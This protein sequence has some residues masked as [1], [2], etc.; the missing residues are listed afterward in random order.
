M[1][2]GITKSGFE[3]EVEKEIIEDIRFIDT[4]VELE[5]T[6]LRA[7]PKL[8]DL[9]FSPADKQRLYDHVTKIHGRPLTTACLAEAMEI[10]QL[11]GDEGKN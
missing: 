3:F 2:K 9:M 6:N 1:I 5:N 11:I 7:A 4:L 10:I 8:L